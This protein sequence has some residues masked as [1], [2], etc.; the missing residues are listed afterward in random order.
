M[1]WHFGTLAAEP[2]QRVHG[3]LDAPGV[4]TPIPVFLIHGV[5]PG[6]TVLILGGIH[7]CEYSSIDAALQL[8]RT[9]QPETVHGRVAVLPIVNT[10]SFF[11]RSIY[12]HPG[13]GKNLNRSFPGAADGT[14]AERLADFIYRTAIQPADVLMDLHGGDMI[15]ALVPFSIYH[16]TGDARLDQAAEDLARTFGIPYVIASRGQVP[17]STYGAAA[18][19]GKLAL[20]AEAGQQG[21]LSRE[22]SAQLQTGV[23][24]CLRKLGVLSGEVE[25]TQTQVLQQFDWYRAD[26]AGLWYPAVSCGDTVTAGQTLGRICDLFGEPL[27][28]VTAQTGGKV[29]FL[30]TSLAINGNDPL[31]ALGDAR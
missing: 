21:I 4:N 8:G 11:A 26:T 5:A 6:P 22:A 31:L 12:V 28:T 15:E 2:G 23:H 18:E 13:D 16:V 7:G 29:L 20:I 30:V 24:N 10:D 19:A 1:T 25:P 14:D 27:R 9:L 17:G 3:T